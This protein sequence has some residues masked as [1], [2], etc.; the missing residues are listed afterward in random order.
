[1]TRQA[2]GEEPPFRG[3]LTNLLHLR[4]ENAPTAFDLV[5]TDPMPKM[6][7]LSRYETERD[8]SFRVIPRSD[9]FR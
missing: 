3:R 7:G 5:L 8:V 4:Q 9:I 6:A 1:M 2:H